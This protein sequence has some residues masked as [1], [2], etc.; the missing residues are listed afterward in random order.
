MTY[1]DRFKSII[2]RMKA[3]QARYNQIGSK[4]QNDD[5][6][7]IWQICQMFWGQ[8]TGAADFNIR[9]DMS[10]AYANHLLDELEEIL[11]RQGW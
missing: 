10:N 9:D 3:N 11:N 8:D 7:R 6:E 4:T 2:T 1:Q 5:E